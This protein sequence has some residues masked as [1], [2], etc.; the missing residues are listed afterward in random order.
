MTDNQTVDSKAKEY[1][2]V[3]IKLSLFNLIITIALLSLITFSG[4]SSVFRDWAL[5]FSGNYFF[6]IFFYNN[7]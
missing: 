5:Y 3:R 1:S 7:T 2:K 6:V 4:L